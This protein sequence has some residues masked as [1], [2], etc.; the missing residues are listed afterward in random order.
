MRSNSVVARLGAKSSVPRAIA[1]F[2]RR[3]SAARLVG[4]QRTLSLAV[5]GDRH[6]APHRTPLANTLPCG[7]RC[8]ISDVPASAHVF[9]FVFIFIFIF[10]FIFVFVLYLHFQ[11]PFPIS[12]II[13]GI[14][15]FGICAFHM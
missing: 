3:H 4:A 8:K 1:W 11:F 12:K 10:V 5:S 7:Q 6:E 13:W 2:T 15:D 14:S 9:V